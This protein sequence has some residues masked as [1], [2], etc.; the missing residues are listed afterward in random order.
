MDDIFLAFKEKE[1]VE[2]FFNYLNSKHQNI[3]FTKELEYGNKLNFLDVTVKKGEDEHATTFI[4]S[5]FRKRTFTG[6]GL[7]YHSY[8]FNNF[9][10]N[11]IWT[12]LHRAYS[13]CSNWEEFHKEV[14]FLLKY[15]KENS[16]PSSVVFPIINK[17][18][19]HQFQP[20][21]VKMDVKKLV[22][23]C[24]F[25]FINNA[26]CDFIKRDLGKFLFKCYPHIDFR[27][28]FFNS[29]TI[30]GLLNHKEKLPTALTSGLVYH[31]QCD[32]CSA[33]YIGQTKK[34]LKT[35]VG[36]HLGVSSRTGSLL[37]RPPISSVRDHI[38]VC[39]S[40]RSYECF[41]SLGSFN[42]QILLRICESLE[43]LMQKPSLNI[44]GS[45]YSLLLT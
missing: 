15:F 33:T 44:E 2:K 7:N 26:A 3:N 40:G 36:E 30:Q 20:K 25:P 14:T 24:K 11:N 45:S 32:A 1:H 8:T 12:L 23:Y 5:I 31:Y 43:I 29:M 6:L 22:M 21:K 4:L 18:L 34:C 37:V 38:E 10:L 27:F 42:N 17:F 35:R 39:G 9:K 19:V 28:I 13:L 16:Y 41:N